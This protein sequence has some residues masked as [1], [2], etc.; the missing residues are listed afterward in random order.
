M[1]KK[2]KLFY[3]DKVTCVLDEGKDTK[4]VE[5]SLKLSIVKS[6][7]AKWLI[8]MYNHMYNH[9]AES[10]GCLKCWK[11]A[12]IFDAVEKRLNGL[13]NLN[14]FLDIDTRA[15]MIHWRKLMII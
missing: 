15:T 2:F 12:G 4:D 8:E 10:D 5:I 11:V 6:L 3:A 7:L 14:P 13:A 9:S 1:K